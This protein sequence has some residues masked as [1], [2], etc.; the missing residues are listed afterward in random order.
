MIDQR[1]VGAIIREDLSEYSLT[2]DDAR[3]LVRQR[4]A[5]PVSSLLRQFPEAAT[6]EAHQILQAARDRAAMESLLLA[7][8]AN[9]VSQILNAAGIPAL[10]Y[11]GVAAATMNQGTWIGR[12]SVDVD[13]LVAVDTVGQAHEALVG[14]GLTRSRQRT[15]PPSPFFKFHSF[16]NAYTGLAKTVDLHWRVDSQHQFDIPFGTLWED[17]RRIV[18]RGVE[19]WTPSPA[20]SILLSAIHGSKEF[21]YTLRHM[22][23]FASAVSG[24]RPAEWAEVEEA[25]QFGAAKPVAVALGIAE[26]CGTPLLPAIAGPWAQKMA[27]Q[28]TDAWTPHEGNLLVAAQGPANALRRGAL[29]AAMAPRPLAVVDSWLRFG[30]MVANHKAR[31]ALGREPQTER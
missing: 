22:L 26:S 12:E 11:K 15:D 16:E 5:T 30:L 3:V 14:A 31:V 9:E 28:F 24:M 27:Q 20:A 1:I 29:R 21:W 6:T 10:I 17:R 4:V 19:V 23:D 18:N 2:A 8:T 13:V 7:R 25:A